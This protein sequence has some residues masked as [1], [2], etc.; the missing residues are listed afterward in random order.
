MATYFRYT[1]GEIG[2]FI[3]SYSS[4]WHSEMDC[5]IAIL[6]WKKIIRWWSGYIAC[7]S[8]ELRFSNSGV[9]EVVGVHPSF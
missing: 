7:K 6:I 8:G 5:N 9:W 3:I 4:P 1:I 2:I